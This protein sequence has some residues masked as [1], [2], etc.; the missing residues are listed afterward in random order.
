MTAPNIGKGNQLKLMSLTRSYTT[1]CS[2]SSSFLVCA[3]YTDP[4]N[5]LPYDILSLYMFK[6]V[7]VQARN[8]D[9]TGV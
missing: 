9:G 1:S 3:E 2:G 4:K 5:G 6:A 7:H 8:L